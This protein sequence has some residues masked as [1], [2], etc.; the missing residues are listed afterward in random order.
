MSDIKIE[1]CALRSNNVQYY[2]SS[3][4]NKYLKAADITHASL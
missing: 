1:K 2:I 3:T 4:F